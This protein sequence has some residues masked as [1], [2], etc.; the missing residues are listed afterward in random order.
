VQIARCPD[1]GEW[2]KRRSG[3]RTTH[4]INRALSMALHNDIHHLSWFFAPRR[5]S[6]LP[7]PCFWR[8]KC[9]FL[10]GR[11]ELDETKHSMF[12]QHN[13][14]VRSKQPV[15]CMEAIHAELCTRQHLTYDAAASVLKL[16]ALLN[17]LCTLALNT[18]RTEGTYFSND[19]SHALFALEDTLS[20][21][22]Q[23]LPH[24]SCLASSTYRRDVHRGNWSRR[25]APTC[26]CFCT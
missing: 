9:V 6:C 15:G 21:S 26:L 18:T 17:M 12:L 8:W 20:I 3:S 22:Q 1:F 24:F 25:A 7:C 19:K 13:W 23:P 10:R 14:T 5:V 2:K 11:L 16:G 4:R